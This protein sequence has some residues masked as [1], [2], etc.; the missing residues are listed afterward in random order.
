MWKLANEEFGHM[1]ILKTCV[2]ED[3]LVDN[4]SK[5]G[6]IISEIMQH[7]RALRSHAD[8]ITSAH[9]QI[10]KG[11]NAVP[12][13]D[14]PSLLKP[15]PQTRTRSISIKPFLEYRFHKNTTEARSLVH[16]FSPVEW[17]N[18]GQHQ[19][20]IIGWFLFIKVH[21]VI[22]FW[23]IFF[24][25]N[26]QINGSCHVTSLKKKKNFKWAKSQNLHH[27]NKSVTFVLKLVMLK[28]KVSLKFE[29]SQT[30]KPCSSRI[31]LH[32]LLTILH[33]L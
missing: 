15:D 10:N 13:F 20:L 12:T 18:P 26:K 2:Q 25:P 3:R 6:K 27:S 24:T 17:A 30:C 19:N 9:S 28:I 4:L 5:F 7:E 33:A 23:V 29:K 32:K 16:R 8:V 14:I 1:Q 31:A 11:L 22:T 21:P